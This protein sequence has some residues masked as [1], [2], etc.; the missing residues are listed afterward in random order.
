MTLTRLLRPEDFGIV[1]IIGSV[2][3][4]FGMFTDLGF[5]AFL[6]RHERTDDPHFLDVIWTIHA[7]RGVA[8]FVLIALASPLIGELL[9]KPAVSLPLAAASATFAID[10]IASLS[11]ITA[12]RKDKSRELSFL[13]LGLLV[14]QTIASILLALWWRNVWALIGAMLLQSSMRSF[15]SYRLFSDSRQR[16]ARDP[17]IFREFLA[18]SR[19][20][21]VSSMITLVLAQSD[22]LILARLFSLHDFGLYALAISITTAPRA[23]ASSYVTRIVFPVYASTWREQPSQ[24][25]SVYYNVR[26][27]GSMLY[28]IGCGALLGGAP[29]LVALLYDPRYAGASMFISLIMISVSL[30]ITNISATELL[31]AAGEMKALVHVNMLRLVWIV[32]AIPAGLL[33]WGPVGVVAAVGLIEVPATISNWVLLH[34]LNVLDLREEM[35]NIGLIA[36]AAVLAFIGGSI[37]LYLLPGL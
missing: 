20:I 21:L 13:D 19:L 30:Q 5:Q 22:K 14:F 31:T 28:A 33:L 7:K 37:V 1:G 8:L 35:L 23:F 11:L 12:L 2:F 16:I 27:R 24:L 6:V 10:G 4:T 9:G 34:R 3:Y 17:V 18:F 26:R 32:V 36:G 25:A 29:L 15:L